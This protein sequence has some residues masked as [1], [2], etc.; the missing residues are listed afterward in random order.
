MAEIHFQA[1]PLHPPSPFSLPLSLPS[2]FPLMKKGWKL[3]PEGANRAAT[4]TLIWSPRS[5]ALPA[6]LPRSSLDWRWLWCTN[7]FELHTRNSH[8]AALIFIL[9][10]QDLRAGDQRVEEIKWICRSF[11]SDIKTA[12]E[13]APIGFCSAWIYSVNRLLLCIWSL[14]KNEGAVDKN[15]TWA[16]AQGFILF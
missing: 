6:C 2:G 3:H 4:P 12:L 8:Q 5:S 15:G 16:A 1:R 10:Q 13:W 14:G 11:E 9:L 7:C